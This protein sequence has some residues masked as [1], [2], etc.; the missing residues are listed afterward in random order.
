MKK[1][2]VI[3]KVDHN[4]ENGKCTECEKDQYQDVDVSSEKYTIDENYIS[5]IQP[6]TTVKQIKEG[7][8]TNATEINIYDKDGE[9][10]EANNIIATGM[11]IE[12]KLGKLTRRLEIV[13]KGD[14]YSDGKADILDMIII[15]YAR[16]RKETLTGAKLIAA[17][18]VKDGKITIED[19]ARI[20]KF[21]L[22]KISEI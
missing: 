21:R 10:L 17:D 7:I 18:I 16:L 15:N 8:E 4:Y 22:H 11:Q 20:N 1:T 3:E 2:Q 5:N 19:L 6:G 14:L 12:L 13:V 9:R